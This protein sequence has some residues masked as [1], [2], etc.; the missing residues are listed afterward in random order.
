MALMAVLRSS[1]RSKASTLDF[2]MR[3]IIK[4]KDANA[5]TMMISRIVNPC[6]CFILILYHTIKNGGTGWD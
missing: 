3:K 5:A 1:S 2:W 6:L 4:R